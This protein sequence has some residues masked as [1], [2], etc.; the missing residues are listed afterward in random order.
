MLNSSILNT[1]ASYLSGMF[2]NGV[3]SRS[4]VSSEAH[5]AFAARLVLIIPS[6]FESGKYYIQK[7]K[8]FFV[9]TEIYY[10]ITITVADDNQNKF[11]RMI[12]YTKLDVMDN[13]S[14]KIAIKEAKINIFGKET[15]INIL[16]DWSVGIRAC[17][18]KNMLKVFGNKKDNYNANDNEYKAIMSYMT[19]EGLNLY[20]IAN[21]EDKEY[22]AL[23]RKIQESTKTK[24]IFNM[25]DVCRQVFR[26]KLVG[27]NIIKY[28]LYTMNNKIIREQYDDNKCNLISNLCLKIKCLPFDQMPFASSL[29][30][31][32]PRLYD[33]LNI[34][35]PIG[36]DHELLSRKIQN[37][38]E[39]K[40]K[41][42]TSTDE[43]QGYDNIDE[44]IKKFNS[45]LYSKHRET[46][47]L[48]RES[49][50]IYINGYEQDTIKILKKLNE[51]S[52]IGIGGY[53]D[54]FNY[55]IK[56]AKIEIDDTK[57]KEIL[58]SMYENSSVA[59]V[60]GAA[61]TGKS[62]LIKY[63]AE[64]MSDKKKICL[65]NT[66]P[67]LENLRRNIKDK[68][69]SFSTIYS[70]LSEHNTEADCD[71]LIIDECSTVSNL[72]MRKILEKCNYKIILLVGDIYQI[73]SISFGN[74]F[75][76]AKKTISNHAIH[77][78]NFTWRSQDQDL[79]NL[80]EMVRNG[81]DKLDEM[82]AKKE[83]S[84]Q[85]DDTLLKKEG[86]SEIILCLNYDGL[87]GINNINNYMQS[88]NPKPA[89]TWELNKYKEGDPILFGDTNRF[90]PVIYNNLQGTIKKIEEDE[91][92][93][94]FTIEIS[95]VVNEL[96]IEGIDLELISTSEK[97]SQV[98]FYVDKYRN[99]DDDD[100]TSSTAIVPF[101]IAYAV[102]IHK[103][104]GLEY[105]SVKVLLTNEIEELITHNIFYT[106][107]TRAK[108][109]LKIYWTPE[110]QR[111]IID[112]IKHKENNKDA[113]IIKRKIEEQK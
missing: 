110:C 47:K 26:K 31:H 66:H 90:L 97:S 39:Q 71:I 102:S 72:D 54:S 53:K 91:E 94:W 41:L 80:W 89:I 13:Y 12:V 70:F 64:F 68:N 22:N 51:L 93:Y 99:I 105:D 48:I 7:K 113:S 92:K 17:E 36:R 52:S 29:K 38:T 98:K 14:I 8:T 33:L 65:T 85:I 44:L 74:W 9:G 3:N 45:N 4:I 60:Y 35:S 77:E 109:K 112:T 16:Y 49:N 2:N 83:Y 103:S 95:K 62:T 42:Y 46:R 30:G 55:Y 10:E 15:P 87:Y 34:I 19:R 58:E 40:N 73:E 37:N 56:E 59:L 63:F 101:S 84:H 5:N 104:Q 11:D 100:A 79:L 67:A 106:A 61:G 78:L 57:K 107:I 111:K 75:T 28:L 88:I 20:D 76:I 23:K 50:N 18:I 81:D 24:T 69:T 108:K 6:K 1:Y 21:M 25:L 32:N 82:L 86:E 43:L 27:S 96:A